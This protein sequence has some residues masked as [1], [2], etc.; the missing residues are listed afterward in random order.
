MKHVLVTGGAGFIGSHLV[1]AYLERGWRVSVIDN[2]S[3][4]DRA[5]LNR[6]AEFFEADLRESATSDLVGRLRPDVISHQAAQVDLRKSV[7][8]P[9]GDA[10][11]NVVGSVRLLQAAV[12]AGTRQ[13]V[14]ASSGGAIY[15]EPQSVPQTEEHPARPMSPYGCAKLAVEHY[16]NAF[17]IVHGL[18]TTALRYANVYG[19]RQSS[20]GEAG[21]V[22]IFADRL[23]RGEDIVIH[24]SGTQTRDFVYV[25]DVVRANLEVTDEGAEVAAANVGTGVET[26]INDLFVRMAA[27]AGV[28]RAAL[29]DAAKPGEQLRSVLDGRRFAPYTTL[30]QG[31]A[32]TLA[33]RRAG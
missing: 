11:I 32:A 25:A 30:Q 24:G 7:A 8:D 21:V 6:R 5:N 26:S 29:H 3:T 27:A 33:S 13:F 31:L 28:R 22:A 9:G 4:G 14:F 20:T 19:P 12:E 18:K 23:L 1:D 15:G 17:R 10:E 2:L 16:M